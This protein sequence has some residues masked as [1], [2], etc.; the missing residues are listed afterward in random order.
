MP[1]SVHGDRKRVSGSGVADCGES[2]DVGGGN[3][4]LLLWKN[5]ALTTEHSLQCRTTKHLVA[6]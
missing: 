1:V 6:T 5:Q 2:P 3:E 4:T